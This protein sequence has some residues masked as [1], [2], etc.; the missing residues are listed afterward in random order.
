MKQIFCFQK[1]AKIIILACFDVVNE[2]CLRTAVFTTSTFKAKITSGVVKGDARKK[3]ML[4]Y[5][6]NFAI[7]FFVL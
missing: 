4:E 6:F 2:I 7:L 1:T 3:I 5:K